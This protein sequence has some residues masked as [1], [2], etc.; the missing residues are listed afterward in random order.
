MGWSNT[1]VEI[2]WAESQPVNEGDTLRESHTGYLSHTH[3]W[4]TWHDGYTCHY[5]SS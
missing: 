2:S 3:T 4:F 1:W 5:R